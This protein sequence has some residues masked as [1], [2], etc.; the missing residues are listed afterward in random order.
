MTRSK[1]VKIFDATVLIA[2]LREMDC[3]DTVTALAKKYTIVVPEGVASEIT[4]QP[5]KSRLQKLAR[6][7]SIKITK[8]TPKAQTLA[9]R[10][11]DDHPFLHKGESEA[12]AL[13]KTEY[14]R[15]CIVSDDKRARRLFRMLKFE[16]TREIL[17]IMQE[18]GMISAEAHAEKIARLDASGFY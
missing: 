6:Q 15:A 14:R 4:K 1:P 13:S 10:F 9:T 8:L 5:G 12:V 2:F 17:C 3:P 7:R 16:W 11:M 18:N